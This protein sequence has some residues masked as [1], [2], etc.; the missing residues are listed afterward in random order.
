ATFIAIVVP[1]IKN[2]AVLAS[3]IVALVSSVALTYYQIEGSLM[4]SSIL[5]MLT[6]Y[7]AEQVK[8]KR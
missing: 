6:G 7:F 5:A 8:E 2:A 4:I 1:T 3:V